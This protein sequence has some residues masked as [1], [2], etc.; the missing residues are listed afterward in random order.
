MANITVVSK[1]RLL[2]G[3]APAI[4]LI[5]SPVLALALIAFG[6]IPSDIRDDQLA[7]F[8]YAQGLDSAL[9]KMEW[10]RTQP[11]GAQIVLDQQRRFADVLDSASEHIDTAEQRDRL[12]ALAQ[13]A[14]PTLDAFRHADPHDETENARM[15]DLHAMVTELEN[16]DETAI[17]QSADTAR[18]RARQFAALA[19]IAGVAVPIGCFAIL[20]RIIQGVRTELRS[21]RTE[22]E[23]ISDNPS[24]KEPSL[25][26][27][28][29]AIDAALE[30]LGFPKPNPMLADQ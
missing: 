12:A 13:A 24:A 6:N 21:M 26:R 27:S 15:R 3:I 2:A 16:A 22:L 5:A 9:Y 29:S 19:I 7:A 18:T 30:R 14:K 8:K 10:G 20:W 28:I 25:A 4:L 17:D 11:D 1:I 23:G